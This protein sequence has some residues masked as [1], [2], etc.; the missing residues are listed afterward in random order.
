MCDSIPSW[1]WREFIYGR[2][3]RVS[4]KNTAQFK[5]QAPLA[6]GIEG[7][8]C[9]GNVDWGY[10]GE[11][12]CQAIWFDPQQRFNCRAVGEWLSQYIFETIEEAQDQAAEWL[13]TY[14]NGRPDMAI[15]GITPAMKL[16]TAAW[17]LRLSPIKSGGITHLPPELRAAGHYFEKKAVPVR[18]SAAF[19]LGFGGF[20][21]LFVQLSLL[22]TPWVRWLRSACAT[23]SWDSMGRPWTL[24]D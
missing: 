22:Q 5:W 8:N 9:C 2:Y 13:W 6:S 21:F 16:K 24:W 14:N 17:V 3:E 18:Q 1:I 4:R 19:S 10:D 12:R 11:R 15:D 20:D 7:T 23:K